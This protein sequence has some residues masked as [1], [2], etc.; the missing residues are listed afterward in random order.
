MGRATRT[1]AL[2]A[3]LVDPGLQGT[4]DHSQCPRLEEGGG[5]RPHPPI[6]GGGWSLSWGA[7]AVP[8]G[9]RCPGCGTDRRFGGCHRGA[10]GQGRAHGHLQP[11]LLPSP[12]GWSLEG[13]RALTGKL[14]KVG[15]RLRETKLT[16]ASLSRRPGPRG[17]GRPGA[18]DPRSPGAWASLCS[19]PD[20]PALVSSTAHTPTPT[21]PSAAAPV[22][23]L[24][25]QQGGKRGDPF[26]EEPENGGDKDMGTWVEGSAGGAQPCRGPGRGHQPLAE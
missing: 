18:A 7:S 4:P 2:G 14:D 13:G 24:W 5:F 6:M 23:G 12:W 8:T 20:S 1:G 22:R 3:Q 16:C 19:P 15:H 11:T 17:Y 10:C 21:G 9:H 26:L 25:G